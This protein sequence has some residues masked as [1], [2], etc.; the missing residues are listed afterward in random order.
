MYIVVMNSKPIVSQQLALKYL[1]F[2][3]CDYLPHPNFIF[4][5][6]MSIVSWPCTLNPL[7]P[8][9]VPQ[10]IQGLASMSLGWQPTLK[11]LGFSI[12]YYPLHPDFIPLHPDSIFISDM[13]IVSW[14]CALNPLLPSLVAQRIQDLALVPF[15]WNI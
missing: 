6:D 3:M 7:L 2:S 15:Q 10:R 5:S 8:S 9:L 1:G 4:I 13:P 11:N 14:P 12:V